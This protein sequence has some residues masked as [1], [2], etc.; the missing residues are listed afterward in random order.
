MDWVSRKS[1]GFM[2]SDSLPTATEDESQIL[3]KA[4][5]GK[6]LEKRDARSSDLD[7]MMLLPSSWGRPGK[8]THRFCFLAP[9][10]K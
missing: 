10:R 3:L 1:R 6:V 8:R 4:A 5:E 7:K 9:L 2:V